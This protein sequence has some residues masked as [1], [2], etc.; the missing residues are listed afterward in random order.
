MRRI[1][2]ENSCSVLS[3]LQ[4]CKGITYRGII[5]GSLPLLSLMPCLLLVHALTL[6]PFP[7]LLISGTHINF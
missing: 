5:I 1:K 6:Q 7:V 4:L 2:W 3:F